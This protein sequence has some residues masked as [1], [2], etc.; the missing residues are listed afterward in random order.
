MVITS[1]HE[2]ATVKPVWL[3]RS[4]SVGVVYVVRLRRQPFKREPMEP[5]LDPPLL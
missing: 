5:P 4:S 3:M 2:V 1:L